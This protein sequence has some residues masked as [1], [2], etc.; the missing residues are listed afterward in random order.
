MSMLLK[1][2][3]GNE[4]EMSF[5][6]DSLAEAQDGFGDSRWATVLIR[7]A[8]QE[9]T[10]EESSPCVNLFEF[11]NLA[12]WLAAVG[13]GEE[14]PGESDSVELLEPDLKFSVSNQS[15]NDA[16]IRIGFHLDG[17]PEKYNVDAEM[18]DSAVL[19]LFIPRE[20]IRTAARTLRS[21][22]AQLNA[23]AKDDL[24]GETDAG[25]LGEPD[26]GLNI[27]DEIKPNPPGAGDGEDNA[28]NH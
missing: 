12:D 22:L 14:G 23:P 5:I 15:K 1:G 13:E 11:Q 4:F 19:D 10:W 17:R 28:G 21:E 2:R 6:R 3:N 7:G 20:N 18:D 8:N 25:V 9:D 24:D 16:T 27:V 26:P